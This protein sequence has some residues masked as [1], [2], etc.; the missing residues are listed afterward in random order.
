MTNHAE[1]ETPNGEAVANASDAGSEQIAIDSSGDD[2]TPLPD[3]D[4][5]RYA[6]T[7]FWLILAAG[8]GLF[9]VFGSVQAHYWLSGRKVRRSTG[10]LDVWREQLNGLPDVAH[11][12]ILKS[13]FLV[14]VFG[15]IGLAVIALWLASVEVRSDL[16]VRDAD[17]DA[18]DARGPT[19]GRAAG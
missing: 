12:T 6:R 8:F 1:P 9:L 2:T 17:S 11:Q 15:F 16:P 19:A 5:G 3:D 14:S 10:V 7:W 4:P 18:T 13:V